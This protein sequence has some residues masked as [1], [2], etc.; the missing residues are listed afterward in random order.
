[1]TQAS[2]PSYI[3]SVSDA[4][5][6]QRCGRRFR[7]QQRG[8]ALL[9]KSALTA[10]WQGAVAGASSRGA[11]AHNRTEGCQESHAVR[12]TED[13]AVYSATGLA[14]KTAASGGRVSVRE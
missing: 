8:R 2:S 6:C 5:R 10:P 3:M 11:G 9:Q 12:I 13:E 4:A 1:M 14:K 7:A